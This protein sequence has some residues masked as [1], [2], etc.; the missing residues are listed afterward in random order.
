MRTRLDDAGAVGV[1]P[2]RGV[3]EL[4][5]WPEQ[6][7]A[8]EHFDDALAAG[9]DGDRQLKLHRLEVASHRRERDRAARRRAQAARRHSK[10]EQAFVRI[11]FAVP[12]REVGDVHHLVGRRAAL[13]GAVGEARADTGVDERA[14]I[15]VG[16]P[17]GTDVVRP[18]VHGGNARIDEFGGAKPNAAVG[19]L[20]CVL[21]AERQH[22]REIALFRA[23]AH[24]VAAGAV[25]EVIVGVD[26]P[27]SAI[28]PRPSSACAPGA[29]RSVPT[30]TIS[31]LRT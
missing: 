4:Q 19:V 11:P 21:A 17:G 25:P 3:D 30:A 10:C 7:L 15:G 31:P 1:V 8:F 28:M 13:K 5:I 9:V 12:A 6:P 2:V 24:N 29:A 26:Q 18:V 14:Q 22:G 23:L 16:M 20:W 27:G